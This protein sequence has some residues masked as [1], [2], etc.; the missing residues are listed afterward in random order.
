MNQS[1]ETMWAGSIRLRG[2][3]HHTQLR[4]AYGARC[5]RVV[6]VE[7]D[8][9]SRSK[10]MTIGPHQWRPLGCPELP[11]CT[12]DQLATIVRAIRKQLR[13]LKDGGGLEIL[14]CDLEAPK[15]AARSASPA[16]LGGPDEEKQ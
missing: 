12:P 1:S 2:R 6:C 10:S 8:D 16:L 14:T 11:E 15:A 13:L 7:N 9:W 5:I 4:T 3:K